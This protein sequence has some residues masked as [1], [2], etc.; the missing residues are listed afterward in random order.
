MIRIRITESA[1][2]LLRS[3]DDF[4]LLMTDVAFPPD[5]FAATR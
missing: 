1:L 5:P 3:R 4:R 2:D